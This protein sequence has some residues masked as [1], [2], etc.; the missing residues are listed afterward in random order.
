MLARFIASLCLA[1][2]SPLA[3]A[4]SKA[5]EERDQLKAEI[6]RL[7]A[8][9]DFAGVEHLAADDLSSQARFADGKWRVTFLYEYFSD[10]ATA[11]FEDDKAWQSALDR[12]RALAK[13][14]PLAWMM[15]AQLLEAR[16]WQARGEGFASSVKPEAWPAFKRYLAQSR[17]VLDDH[18]DEL[19]SHP[20]WYSARLRMAT[21]LSEGDALS[22]AVF[23]VG[24]RRYPAFHAIYFNRM[25]H[26]SPNWG[27]SKEQM[28]ELLNQVVRQDDAARQEAMYA[29][30]VWFSDEAGYSLVHKK[31]IDEAA[32]AQDAEALV[33][34][35]PDQ[36]NVQ[37]MFF[38][39]CERSDKPLTS[40]IL[41]LVNLPAVPEVWGRNLSILDTC[42]DWATGKLD[43]FVLRVH[44]GDKVEDKLVR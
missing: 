3:L 35:F 9:K 26:V 11:R 15:V 24:V 17:D 18:K 10:A 25:R 21:G 1:L 4:Q 6:F 19:S 22:S 12:V 38:M 37:K 13:R 43:M 29:R 14:R 44:D 5:L 36:R 40:K 39:A 32:L 30:L 7:T 42:R 41:S 2:M 20:A 33:D 28:L 23:Q 8:A 34:A 31:E 16:A 27:G